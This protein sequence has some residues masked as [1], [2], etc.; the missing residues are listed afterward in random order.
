MGTALGA[1]WL[2][3]AE[4]FEELPNRLPEQRLRLPFPAAAGEA[5]GFSATS[6]ALVTVCLCDCSRDEAASCRGLDLHSPKD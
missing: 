5:S 4:L 1:A 6:P 3:R 2:G